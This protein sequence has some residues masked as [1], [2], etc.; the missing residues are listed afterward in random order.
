MVT[1]GPFSLEFSEIALDDLSRLDPPVAQR[2]LA[3]L[4]WLAE[5]FDSVR[6][7]SLTGRWQGKFRERIGDHRAIYTY[8]QI[9]RTIAVHAVGHRRE[10]Y[11]FR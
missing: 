7:V 10:I 4:R 5:N 6:P 9:E 11:G 3:R 2:I 1:P 8:D